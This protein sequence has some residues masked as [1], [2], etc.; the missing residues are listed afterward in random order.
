MEVDH[1]RNKSVVSTTSPSW[2]RS[3]RHP[4]SSNDLKQCLRL[5]DSHLSQTAL[6][7]K[8]SV[9]MCSKQCC[10]C[11]DNNSTSC[12]KSGRKRA[13]RSDNTQSEIRDRERELSNAEQSVLDSAHAFVLELVDDLDKF[14]CVLDEFAAATN[15]DAIR[16]AYLEATDEMQAI[17]NASIAARWKIATYGC[18]LAVFLCFYFPH[19]FS[20]CGNHFH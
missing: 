7:I 1:C 9:S 14:D 5:T 13:P 12:G 4:A 19:T 18:F 8:G 17:R 16:T 2:L 10:R 6:R 11:S 20:G 3:V 15:P